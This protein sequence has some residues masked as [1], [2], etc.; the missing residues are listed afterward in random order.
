MTGMETKLARGK[1]IAN[2]LVS[3]LCLTFLYHPIKM[4]ACNV[5]L[6]APVICY[7]ILDVI[8][9]G[10][11]L[12]KC[13]KTC[14]KSHK[15]AYK[16]SEHSLRLGLHPGPRWGNLRRS[17]DPLVGFGMI[18]YCHCLQSPLSLHFQCPSLKRKQFSGS[19]LY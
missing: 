9:S 18:N 5:T 8:V 10:S 12:P 17:P 6:P 14:L 11:Q 7:C 13:T 1:C 2:A 16:T 3:H 15:I 4:Q 19:Q